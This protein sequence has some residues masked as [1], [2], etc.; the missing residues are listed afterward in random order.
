MSVARKRGVSQKPQ[1]R[2]AY[3]AIDTSWVVGIPEATLTRRRELGAA[4]GEAFCTSVARGAVPAVTHRR[5]QH[6]N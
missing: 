6:H 3:F 4:D 5:D 1:D 2:E